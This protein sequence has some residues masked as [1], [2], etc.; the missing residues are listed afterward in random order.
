MKIKENKRT[1][2]RK[3]FKNYVKYN[4]LLQKGGREHMSSPQ[5]KSVITG[6]ENDAKKIKVELPIIK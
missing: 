1:Y 3:S 5:V 6:H 4:N 2:G